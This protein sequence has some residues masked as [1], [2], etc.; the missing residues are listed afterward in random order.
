MEHSALLSSRPVEGPVISAP[1]LDIAP[2]LLVPALCLLGWL[3]VGN[4]STWGTLTVAGLAMG[5][6]VFIIASGMTLVFGLMDVMNFGH[7]VFISLGA[8]VAVTLFQAWQPAIGP[9]SA[10]LA[11]ALVLAAM[12]VSMLVGGL[13]GIAFERVII[14]PVYGAHLKQILTTMG[15]M[16]VGEELLKTLW[17][18]GQ[19]PLPLPDSLRGAIAFGD[20]SVETYRLVAAAFGLIAFALLTWLLARTKLGLLIRAG[21]QN[22]IM[23]EAMGYR[24][25]RLFIGVFALGAAMAGAGG[26]LWGLYQ[27]A[28]TPQMGS[29]LN[30]LVFI[31]VIIGGLGSPL[32]CLVAAT[33]VGLSANYVGFL[34][35]GVAAFCNIGVMVAVL[36][37]RPQGLYPLT[38]MELK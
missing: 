15:G 32:G 4:V 10:A 18:P 25:N 12:L 29:Q 23:V 27:Q 33:V 6:I 2:L 16:I 28:V 1:R 21:V 8:L 11:I 26:V 22:R 35:P 31:V 3:G 13:V 34:A 17:G 38:R 14:R 20:M 37:W 36:L 7:G 9:S 24:I 30:I 5:M 19:R